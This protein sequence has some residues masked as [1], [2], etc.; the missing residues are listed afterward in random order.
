[1]DPLAE[2]D[3]EKILDI[4]VGLYPIPQET[5]IEQENLIY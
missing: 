2:I 4:R 5:I 3:Y 1:M